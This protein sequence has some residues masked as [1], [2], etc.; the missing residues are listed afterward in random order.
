[1]ARFMIKSHQIKR[2]D[3]FDM[4]VVTATEFKLN[5]G[6]YL[7]MVGDD[8]IAISKNGKLIAQLVPYRQSK[9][10]TLV[11]ILK[12]SYLP[13]DFDGDYRELIGE[14]RRRDYEDLD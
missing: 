8:T 10:D 2:G 1:M 4:T 13:E 5:L 14:M 11:G 7:S 9:T 12:D 3:R 6:K